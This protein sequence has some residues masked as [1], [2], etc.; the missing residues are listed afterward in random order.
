MYLVHRIH[1]P[2]IFSACSLLSPQWNFLPCDE[3]EGDILS[4]P[5]WQPNEG[6]C[7]VVY[8]LGEREESVHNIA[9]S[10]LVWAG[11]MY[12]YVAKVMPFLYTVCVHTFVCARVT[13]ECV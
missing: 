5:S 10:A 11:W 13:T 7:A 6:G 2:G 4:S 8:R 1:W 12:V 3:G 9:H